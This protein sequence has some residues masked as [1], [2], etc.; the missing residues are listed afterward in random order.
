MELK[1]RH[2]ALLFSLLD[3]PA[4][5]LLFVSTH[6]GCGDTIWGQ[7]N[8]LLLLLDGVYDQ[9]GRFI[10]GF[11]QGFRR[12]VLLKVKFNMACVLLIFIERHT[13]PVSNDLCLPACFD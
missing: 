6:H 7:F 12:Q 11:F 2:Q 3:D 1:S 13:F 4:G 10:G 5:D 8:W 9:I